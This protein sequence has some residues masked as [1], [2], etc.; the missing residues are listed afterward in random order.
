MNNN[1]NEELK[2]NEKSDSSNSNF[3]NSSIS[4]LPPDKKHEPDRTIS[5]NEDS[6]SSLAK[7]IG[8]LG[9]SFG[10]ISKGI[11]SGIGTISKGIGKGIG[12]SIKSLGFSIGSIGKGI[13][14]MGKRLD[15]LGKGLNNLRRFG[16]DQLGK[17]LKDIRKELNLRVWQKKMKKKEFHIIFKST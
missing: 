13:E 9:K 5:N 16:L 14:T 7:F 2:Q 10:N 6:S 8:I 12:S 3:E 1:W 15:M 4:I 17:G 11:G